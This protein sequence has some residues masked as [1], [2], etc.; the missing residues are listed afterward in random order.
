MNA[1]QKYANAAPESG[2]R[3]KVYFGIALILDKR[4][5]HKTSSTD[6]IN[7]TYHPTPKPLR[8][9]ERDQKAMRIKLFAHMAASLYTK[10]EQSEEWQTLIS[11]ITKIATAEFVNRYTGS[12]HPFIPYT[13]AANKIIRMAGEVA[14]AECKKQISLKTGDE[15]ECFHT[16]KSTMEFNF[17]ILKIKRNVPAR[18]RHLMIKSHPYCSYC[19]SRPPEVV[20][21]VDHITPLA[22]G[23][24]NEE[25]NLQVLCD[26]CNLGKGAMK[27]EATNPA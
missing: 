15:G 3:S 7:A 9:H 20:L 12:L 10:K 5:F 23:G 4:F 25:I 2:S 11:E 8:K 13:E 17:P 6:F 21:H 18:I 27:Q 24:S 22:H 1:K 19:G 14:I 16:V 26:S